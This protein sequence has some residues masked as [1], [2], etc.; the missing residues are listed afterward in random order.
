MRSKFCVMLMLAAVAGCAGSPGGNGAASDTSNL[1]YVYGFV[2]HP[3]TY[4]LKNG[5]ITSL[6]ILSDAGGTSTG[7][8]AAIDITRVIRTNRLEQKTTFSSINALK[9]DRDADVVL[10]PRDLIYVH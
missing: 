6:D 4:P 8:D 5:R 3:G 9:L 1:V 2:V 10:R 7:G